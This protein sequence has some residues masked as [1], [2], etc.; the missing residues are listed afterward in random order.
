MDSHVQKKFMDLWQKYFD[1]AELPIAFYYTDDPK[2]AEPAEKPS[3]HHCLISD[4]NKVR[5]G[6]TIAFNKDNIGCSGGRRYAGFSRD[7]PD[8]FPY[9]LSCGLPDKMEGE[10]YKMAPH[11]VEDMMKYVPEVEHEG[12]WMVFKRWD[13]LTETDEPDV[14]IV[15]AEAD[16]LSGLFMLANFDYAEPNGVKTPMTSGCG[17]IILYPFAE[18]DKE[19]PASIIG[20]FDPSARP[21]IQSHKLTFAAPM[22]RFDQLIGYMEGSFLMSDLWKEITDRME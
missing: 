14:V 1:N 11:L 7:L 15:F 13:K 21:H 4:L 20:M 9:F 3:G 22:N 17:S 19:N 6:R 12:E 16:V 18:K 5:E 8:D 2:E 10:R